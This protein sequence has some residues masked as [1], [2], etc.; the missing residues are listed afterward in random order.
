MVNVTIVDRLDYINEGVAAKAPC[1][2]GTTAAITLSGLQTIDTV[3]VEEG[4]RVLV[5]DQADAVENGIYNAS[6]EDWERTADC[7]DR[8][9]LVTGTRIFIWD[10]DPTGDNHRSEWIC[11]T[12]DPITVGTDE[13]EF[14]R[15]CCCPSTPTP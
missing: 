9:D 7:N 12:D 10:G 5:K 1:R 2:V 14:A 8:R 13:L 4:D 15:Y 6:S 3:L 11:I